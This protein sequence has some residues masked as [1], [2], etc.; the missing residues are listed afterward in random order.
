[1]DTPI[2]VQ[3]TNTILYCRYWQPTVH[4]YREQ[5]GFPVSFE[6]DW[7][8]EFALTEDSFL[9]VA[10]ARQATIADVKGQGITLTLKVPDVEDTRR[11]LAGQGIDT[12]AIRHRWGAAIFY[13]YDPE[14]HRLEFWSADDSTE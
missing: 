13:C 10:D 6:N 1:M 7:F 14:G 9:S 8:V 4:F 12:T 11:K 3:R 2:V 5:L